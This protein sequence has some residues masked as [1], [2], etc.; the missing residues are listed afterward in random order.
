MQMDVVSLSD[1]HEN[2][3]WC[4]FTRW[5]LLARLKINIGLN[6]IKYWIFDWFLDFWKLGF[7]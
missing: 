7:I 3:T 2:G 6:E 4:L 5:L 1:E